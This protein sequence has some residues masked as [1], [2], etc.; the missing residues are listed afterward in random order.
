MDFEEVTID[1]KNE[2]LENMHEA[3]T[4]VMR[5]GAAIK[6]N[7]ET[8]EHSKF[9]QSRNVELRLR[10]NLFANLIHVKSQPGLVTR[11]K[12]ID[13]VLI[14]QNT[15]GEYSCLEHES[16]PGVVESAKVVTRVKTEQIARYAFD[17]ARKNARRKLTCVHKAN[18]MKLADGL[19]LKICTEIAKEYPDIEFNNMIIDNCSMQASVGFERFKSDSSFNAQALRTTRNWP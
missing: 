3:I 15:E 13:I 1:S 7:I 16:V 10:L 14:R 6:G 8:R 11:H 18:I 4:S 5:N 12:D 17:F 2:D 9:F 19:F